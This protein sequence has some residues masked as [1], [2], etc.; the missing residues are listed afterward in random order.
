MIAVDWSARSAPSPARPVK[1]AIYLCA[2]RA[3]AVQHPSYHRTRA[4]AMARIEAL[5]DAA[6]ARGERVFLGFDFAFGYPIGFAERLTGQASALAVW[7][8]LAERIEDTPRN[9]NNRF[10]V[11]AEINRAFPGIGPMWGCP[12]RRESADLPARGSERRD[13]G[14]PERRAVERL[15]PSAQPVWKLFTAGSVGSQSLLGLARLAGLRR[16][17]GDAM[18]VWPMQSGWRAPRA[19]ITLAEIYPSMMRWSHLIPLA[20]RYPGALY[21]IPDAQQVRW[22]VDSVL[23]AQEL[24]VWPDMFE[25]D[26]RSD[27]AREEGW[28]FGAGPDK[29]RS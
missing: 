15:V 21:H 20:K 17:Y 12:A 25:G 7:D 1:D 2:G 26:G 9:D 23:T 18:E 16:R 27:T 29:D 10:D 13:H 28:I 3:G 19:P 5:L 11:A 4:E 24:P 14:M 8:W 6:L 22:V